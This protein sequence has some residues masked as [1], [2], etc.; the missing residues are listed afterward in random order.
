MKIRILK[1]FLP[2]CFRLG[3]KRAVDLG[4]EVHLTDIQSKRIKVCVLNENC[5]VQAKYVHL[6]LIISKTE[7]GRESERGR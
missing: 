4:E 3:E 2:F 7:R 6:L 1:S 5:D